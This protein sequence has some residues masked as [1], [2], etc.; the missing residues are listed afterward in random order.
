MVSFVTCPDGRRA[1]GR[2]RFSA[3]GCAQQMPARQAARGSSAE[4]STKRDRP[5]TGR[6]RAGPVVEPLRENDAGEVAL[7][8]DLNRHAAPPSCSGEH[9]TV[10]QGLPGPQR[11]S[12][13]SDVRTDGSAERAQGLHGRMTRLHDARRDAARA[14]VAWRACCS[15]AAGR[16][17]GASGCGRP[18]GRPTP[19]GTGTSRRSDGWPRCG[20]GGN[21][22][23]GGGGGH[24]CAPS[25]S[26]GEI[27]CCVVVVGSITGK[28]RRWMSTLRRSGSSAPRPR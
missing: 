2:V 4:L 20:G 25:G 19:V 18:A 21:R 13:V 10:A 26:S 7:R 27:G 22:G 28:A 14:P 16:D 11:L 3:Q 9:S 17:R 8:R 6:W 12:G 24:R 1:R 15:R 5:G 23:D